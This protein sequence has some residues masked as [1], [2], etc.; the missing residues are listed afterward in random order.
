[1]NFW[2]FSHDFWIFWRTSDI[3][4][5]SEIF[6]I[7]IT[8]GIIVRS[9]WK[10]VHQ[11][12]DS[13]FM[14][15]DGFGNNFHDRKQ[16]E[17]L[18]RRR[19]DAGPEVHNKKWT[20]FCGQQKKTSLSHPGT[21]FSK[22]C[23]NLQNNYGRW[24]KHNKSKHKPIWSIIPDG[25]YQHR[26]SLTRT[27]PTCPKKPRQKTKHLQTQIQLKRQ[28]QNGI[29]CHSRIALHSMHHTKFATPNNFRKIIHCST[30]A[31]NFHQQTSILSTISPP[32]AS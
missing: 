9:L 22:H 17:T 15:K 20:Q 6:K 1:M 26:L 29:G 10:Y 27:K 14:Q 2:W 23:G 3:R 16:F 11:A 31:Q 24:R 5:F 19:T 18:V 32:I 4:L 8:R 12:S 13:N 7:K 21:L 25:S 30:P 28:T